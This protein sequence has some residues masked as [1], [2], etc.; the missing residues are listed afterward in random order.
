MK[1]AFTVLENRFPELKGTIAVRSRPVKM[2]RVKLKNSS[3][4]E[5][6]FLLN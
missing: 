1:S 5:T 2:E 3:F 4:W 6:E